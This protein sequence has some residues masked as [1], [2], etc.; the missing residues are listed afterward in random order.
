MVA[1]NEAPLPAALSGYPEPFNDFDL[2]LAFG[3]SVAR[4]DQAPRWKPT[5][6][7]AADWAMRKL[8]ETVYEARPV[9]DQAKAWRERID[10][11][12][13]RELAS[14]QRRIE[15]FQNLLETYGLEQREASDGKRK[16]I[17]LP[18]GS[19]STR[20]SEDERLVVDR[21]KFL[22][23]MT[24]APPLIRESLTRT[25][26]KPVK[27]MRP[28]VH[29]YQRVVCIAC[30]AIVVR[31]DGDYEPCPDCGE[32]VETL[33]SFLGI[34]LFGLADAETMASGVF[35]L[36][37]LTFEPPAAP[38]ATVRLADERALPRTSP[39]AIT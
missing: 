32:P 18:A 34:P 4:E 9:A 15:F 3:G 17:N 12:E 6:D 8:A 27:E 36:D 31:R 19:I 23:C 33:E 21:E 37:G 26:P 22:A 11:W 25:E 5:D 28:L 14:L 38:S 35:R 13:R 20:G 16:T 1:M 7:A 10:E 2:E 30:G 39:R 29:R 24:T